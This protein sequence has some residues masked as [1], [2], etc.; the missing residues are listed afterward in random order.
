MPHDQS[1]A[2]SQKAREKQGIKHVV[3]RQKFIL[4]LESLGVTSQTPCHRCSKQK[5]CLAID[6]TL[7]KLTWPRA[8]STAAHS[9][10]PTSP[11]TCKYCLCT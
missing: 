3:S 7:P 9:S 10:L 5:N 2:S 4:L 1:G 8:N 11:T 6:S